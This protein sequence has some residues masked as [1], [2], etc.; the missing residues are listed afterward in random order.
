MLARLQG[1]R[2]IAAYMVVIYHCFEFLH[3]TNLGIPQIP[4][5]QAGV[6]M[7]FAISGV[8]MVWIS[9]ERD[10][11]ASF[12]LG[13][14]ARIVPL[15]WLATFIAIGLIA[16]RPWLF[17]HSL[18]TFETVISS[19]TFV[20]SHN[21]SGRL[22]PILLVGWT[23]NFEMM[24]YA[25]L[26]ISLTA[27]KSVRRSLLLVLMAA[28][29]IIG[30]LAPKTS[31]ANF[32]ANP[33]F[34]E[35]GFGMAIA[36]IIRR[37]RTSAIVRR[38]PSILF[39]ALGVVGLGLSNF[40]VFD[41]WVRAFFWGV[42]SALIV[43]GIVQLDVAKP[44]TVKNAVG[45]LGDASFSAY[46]LHPFVLTLLGGFAFKPLGAGYLAA[47]LVVAMTIGLTALLSS[48][49]YHLIEAPARNAVRDFQLALAR[50]PQARVAST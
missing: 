10:T 48:L 13:R 29:F 49:S 21:S 44:R 20:P 46:L 47:V 34:L 8:I 28:V 24:F 45:R 39:I 30:L 35:F 43:L 27:P 33:M 40:I 23:L 26:S 12:M 7:F 42:P 16:F 11:A 19:L 41:D 18:V 25:L 32:Y 50:K 15:Y 17:P 31:F 6:D 1:L 36:A 14:L 4:V 2:A 22:A 9:S 37:K 38:I 5:G 3:S